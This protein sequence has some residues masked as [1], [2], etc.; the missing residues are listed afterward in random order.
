M[1]G[2]CDGQADHIGRASGV[3]QC[4]A[5][6]KEGAPSHDELI[7]KKGIVPDHPGKGLKDEERR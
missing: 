4:P 7:Q 2:I 3:L 5:A 1:P 6:P